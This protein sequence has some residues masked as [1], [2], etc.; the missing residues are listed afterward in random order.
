VSRSLF[1]F[2]F[3][4]TARALADTLV[5]EGWQVAGTARE[6][7]ASALPFDGRAPVPGLDGILQRGA[8]LLVSIPPGEAGDRVLAV[9]GHEIAAHASRI[10][11]VGLLSTTGVYGDRAG[12][13]VD[14]A[15]R[16][17]PTSR[18]GRLRVL[19]EEQWLALWREHGLPVHVFR[20]AGIYGPGRNPL[21]QL[22][23]GRARS[24][25]KPGQVFSRIHVADIVQVLR[26]SLARPD[27]GAAYNVCDDEA[28]PPQDVVA[29]AARLLGRE[30]PPEVRFED[31][32]MTEM[33]RS[34][35]EENKRVRN[36]RI[37]RDLGVRLLYPNYRAGLDALYAPGAY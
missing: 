29:Y 37:K 1:C 6:A 12:G 5:P 13:W 36:D 35:Y 34:F 26:A 21:A 18:R 22:R 20:L 11:W 32:E 30:P 7:D 31:A 3:G 8:A 2:G 25:V 16:Y 33:A 28:A 24:I 10:P 23:A 14:E 15:S 17:A 27:P 4:Y 19:A 9:H